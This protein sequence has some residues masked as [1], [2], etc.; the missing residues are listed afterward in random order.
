V[1]SVVF[2]M[3]RSTLG[4]NSNLSQA[5]LKERHRATLTACN[6]SSMPSRRTI[7]QSGDALCAVIKHAG[8]HDTG[9]RRIRPLDTRRL[10]A[11]VAIRVP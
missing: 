4:A 7:D 2:S 10:R 1:K 5:G 9:L 8:K 3:I 6:A 11:M